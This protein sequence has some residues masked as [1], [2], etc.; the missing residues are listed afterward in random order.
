M[1]ASP[2]KE[3][4]YGIICLS[5]ATSD[6]SLRSVNP[7]DYFILLIRQKSGDHWTFPKGHP[8][9]SDGSTK[10]TALRELK[11]E[12]GLELRQECLLFGGKTFSNEYDFEK[13]PRDGRRVIVHK[14]NVFYVGLVGSATRD[15]VTIQKSEVHEYQWVCLGGS[16]EWESTVTYEEDKKVV[17][18]VVAEL[19][20][21]RSA[22]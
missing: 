9:P 20:Q 11:E 22:N 14:I 19:E 7:S 10:A 15:K 12:T 17:R 1:A 21:S 6:S 4:S 13:K 16:K 5:Q 18:S 8:K 3:T 2:R